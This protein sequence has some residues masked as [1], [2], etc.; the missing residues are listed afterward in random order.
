MRARFIHIL[1]P[2]LKNIESVVYRFVSE[3]QKVTC[4]KLLKRLTFPQKLALISVFAGTLTAAL[5]YTMIPVRLYTLSIILCGVAVAVSATAILLKQKSER[6]PAYAVIFFLL[7]AYSLYRYAP[8]IFP[9]GERVRLTFK[10]T[11]YPV[12]RRN[13]FSFDAR[14]LRI[15]IQ[16]GALIDDTL[17]DSNKAGSSFSG[18]DGLNS[19]GVRGSRHSIENGGF[20]RNKVR[21]SGYYTRIAGKKVHARVGGFGS[22]IKRGDTVALNGMFFA[23]PDERFGSYG[24]YLRSTGT[25]ALFEGYNAGGLVKKRPFGFSPIMLAGML[26]DYIL[27]VNKRV[28]PFP[29]N[30][31]ASALLT[32]DRSRLPRHMTDA[33]RKSGTMHILAVSGLHIGYLVIFIFFILRLFR[34]NRTV[35]YVLLVIFVLF[36]MIFVGEK[37]SVRR[38]A[39]MT[40][41]GIFCYIFDRDKN[42]LN[43]LSLAFFILWLINPLSIENPGFLLSFCAVFGILFIAGSLYK[44]LRMYMPGL[45]AGSIAASAAVQVYIF[46]VMTAFF[47]E[48]P[49]INIVANIPIVPLAGVSLALEAATL[50][51]YP[52]ILPASLLLAEVNTVVI[53]TMFR[54]ARLFAGVPPV[55][56]PHFPAAAIPLYLLAVSI[57]L[58]PMAVRK[59]E[60]TV[61]IVQT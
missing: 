20:G 26:R 51:L 33:F 46:P 61:G 11:S 36:F 47:Q 18:E 28:L 44:K 19:D 15:E 39:S 43:A 17:S 31:F 21:D 2:S 16:E 9:F 30:E 56:I 4:S 60:G 53:A 58:L 55:S 1:I 23:L 59:D 50:V 40:L 12:F 8:D 34:L 6:V 14:V 35:V 13:A 37:P 52:V 57:L 29:Q 27:R 7:C 45:L 54:L 10:I 3:Y 41:C 25:G 32:G 22:E 48:F 49:Y 5:S 24:G 38:A 42:Y